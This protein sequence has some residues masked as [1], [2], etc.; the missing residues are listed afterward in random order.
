M[1]EMAYNASADPAM[2]GFSASELISDFQKFTLTA[3]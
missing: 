1:R 3:G 2:A